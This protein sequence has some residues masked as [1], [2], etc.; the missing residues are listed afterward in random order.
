MQNFLKSSI[1]YLFSEEWTV[2]TFFLNLIFFSKITEGRYPNRE[3]KGKYKKVNDL[4]N[5]FQKPANNKQSIDENISQ[6]SFEYTI[7]K[8]QT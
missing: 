7:S 2:L 3:Q 5:D 6:R 4:I 8:I 1:G